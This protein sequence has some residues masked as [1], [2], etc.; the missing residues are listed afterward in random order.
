MYLSVS[1]RVFVRALYT[2]Q[3][4][5]D[6][7]VVTTTSNEVV[8][9]KAVPLIDLIPRPVLKVTRVG[10]QMVVSF[11]IQ[12]VY[13]VRPQLFFRHISHGDSM[14]RSISQQSK[15]IVYFQTLRQLKR[16]ERVNMT[17]NC[18]T[19]NQVLDFSKIKISWIDIYR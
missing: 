4:S 1:C 18:E 11:L 13:L 3:A 2:V 10:L 8:L 15:A 16:W 5:K 7:K 17:T 12:I 14:N 6:A 19:S 9:E